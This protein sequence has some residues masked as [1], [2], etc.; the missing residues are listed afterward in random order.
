M[1][2][3][4]AVMKAIVESQ[5]VQ[6]ENQRLQELF[7]PQNLFQWQE[8]FW[9]DLSVLV[10]TMTL[11]KLSEEGNSIFFF[12]AETIANSFTEFEYCPVEGITFPSLFFGLMPTYT[13]RMLKLAWQ[14]KSQIT[15]TEALHRYKW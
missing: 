9:K 3:L 15:S 10:K 6:L 4:F 5:M 2:E 11:K 13:K 14:E 12:A 7:P 8:Q 1:E